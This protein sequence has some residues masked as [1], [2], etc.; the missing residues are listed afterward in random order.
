M[1]IQT[2]LTANPMQ[3]DGQ[4]LN[5]ANDY[6]KPGIYGMS[7]IKVK[8][9]IESLFDT[10]QVFVCKKSS[11]NQRAAFIAAPVVLWKRF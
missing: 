3:V 11:P 1:V 10:S 2:I 5:Q 8:R 7:K 4:T 6:H 9:I